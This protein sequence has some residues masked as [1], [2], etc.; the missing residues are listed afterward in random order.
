MRDK[1]IGIL[2]VLMLVLVTI[3]MIMP[4]NLEVKANPV[5][6]RNGDDIGLDYNFMWNITT[7]LSNVVHKYPPGMIPMGRAFATW[8][9]NYTAQ[10]IL[11]PYMENECNL[12][13][14]GL[15]PL[16]PVKDKKYRDWYYTSKLEVNGCQLIIN[17]GYPFGDNIP[18]IEFFPI[19]SAYETNSTESG[20]LNHNYTFPNCRVR[21][22]PYDFLSN[23]QIYPLG[24]SYTGDYMNVSF[25]QVNNLSGIVGNV[26]YINTNATLPEQ[27]EGQ[28]FIMEEEQGCQDKLD[29][30][31]DA[32]GVVLIYDSARGSHYVNST[33][34]SAPSYESNRRKTT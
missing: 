13:D 10:H 28:L 23:S 19:A 11:K 17:G 16:G 1:I 18:I 26:T 29:N 25:T 12:S 2:I 4:R 20:T 22:T 8:G 15:L 31:T 21:T 34:C 3:T 5:G 6:G 33:N 14:V 27:Q 32:A 9:D 7:E 24:G 30:V